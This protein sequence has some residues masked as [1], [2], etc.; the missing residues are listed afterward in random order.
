M[1]CWVPQVSICPFCQRW[2]KWLFLVDGNQFYQLLRDYGLCL[3]ARNPL[4]GQVELISGYLPCL[5]GVSYYMADKTEVYHA[6]FFLSWV[7]LCF[8]L[9][10]HFF[11]KEGLMKPRVAL[12]SQSFCLSLQSWGSQRASPCP[13]C[14]RSLMN[15][16][17]LSQ[18]L[19]SNSPW[20]P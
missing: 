16:P 9:C 13:V 8:L 18:L 12:T 14:G 15:G 2:G 17:L 20:F 6:Q 3:P 10:C 4:I 19:K 7:D 11:L 5:L 1:C